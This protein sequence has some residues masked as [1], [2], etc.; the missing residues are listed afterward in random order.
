QFYMSWDEY[1]TWIKQTFGSHLSMKQAIKAMEDLQ[2]TSSAVTYSC[3]FN[4]LVSAIATSGVNYPARHLCIKYLQGLKFHIHSNPAIFA[5]EDDLDHLQY[6]AEK[7]DNLTYCHSKCSV[8]DTCKNASTYST[9]RT[10]TTQSF[11]SVQGHTLKNSIPESSNPMDLG[12]TQQTSPYPR[13]TP[14][15]KALFRSKG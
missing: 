11:Q 8:A 3:K 5:I 6:E 1:A 15:Q 13:L 4:E 2:Q 9:S 12:N 14:E 10:S 7:L